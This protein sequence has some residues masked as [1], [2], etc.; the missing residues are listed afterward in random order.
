MTAW[1]A[2]GSSWTSA[3]SWARP[4][5]PRHDPAAGVGAADVQ[6]L[7]AD[8][9]GLY[10][11]DHRQGGRAAQKAAAQILKKL[12]SVLAGGTYLEGRPGPARA[13]RHRALPPRV[14]GVRRRT[15][16]QGADRLRRGPDLRP[17]RRRP[18]PRGPRA[19]QPL[20][21]RGRA[22]N[23]PARTS[24]ACGT[25]T[26]ARLAAE[27]ADL[28]AQLTQAK[29]AA[30][31]ARKQATTAQ[32]HSDRTQKAVEDADQAVRR[33]RAA[34]EQAEAAGAADTTART[35]RDEAATATTQ[36]RETA[37]HTEELATRLNTTREQIAD[38]RTPRRARPSPKGR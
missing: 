24:P 14:D 29:R 21:P 22:T 33:A 30:E 13:D 34:L 2:A 25:R 3:P 18:A 27:E 23:S 5:F 15:T 28:T 32:G 31:S 37:A 26:A 9:A 6:L 10:A 17:P 12:D 4:S 35:R 36:A 38:Q 11:I 16:R 1:S 8:V 7:A 20:F 19:R